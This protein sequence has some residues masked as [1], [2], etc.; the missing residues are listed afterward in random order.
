MQMTSDQI[1]L[2]IGIMAVP[3][4]T[5]NVNKILQELNV[6]AQVFYDHDNIG[7]YK[8]SK[9]VFTTLA[10]DESLTHI[11]VL[12]DDV[13]LCENFTE[14]V[15]KVIGAN[16]NVIINLY[17]PKFSSYDV[18]DCPYF[19]FDLFTMFSGQAIIMPRQIAINCFTWCDLHPNKRKSFLNADDSS[20][21]IFALSN[22]IPRIGTKVSLV[23]HL[24]LT[25]PKGIVPISHK[26]RLFLDDFANKNDIDWQV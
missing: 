18:S 9:R 11:L 3:Q 17:N 10:Q 8:A 5:A 24:M 1:K 12:Q 6:D 21:K 14:I 26:S 15:Y 19:T 20:I 4:R 25:N 23:Q 13:A 16:P 7:T 2:G 22:N